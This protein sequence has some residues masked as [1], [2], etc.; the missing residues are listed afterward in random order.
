MLSLQNAKIYKLD[1]NPVTVEKWYQLENMKT[2][3]DFFK[4]FQYNF[5]A[6]NEE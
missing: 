5:D 3:C 6:D 4:L 1:A 2:Y